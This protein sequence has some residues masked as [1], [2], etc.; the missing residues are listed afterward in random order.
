VLTAAQNKERLATGT[1]GGGQ[2]IVQNFN[3]PEGTDMQTQSQIAAA[4]SL[5]LRSARRNT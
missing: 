1:L 5:G 2:R 4:A 3:I